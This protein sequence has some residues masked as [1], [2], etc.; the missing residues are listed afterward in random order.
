M[1]KPTR[2][3]LTARAKDVDL[4]ILDV[5][6]VLTDGGLYYGPE[7]EAL[8]RFNVRDGHG[9][10]LARATGLRAAILTGRRS[11]IV[12][13]R[14][15]ELGISPISQGN[16]DKVAGLARLLEEAKVPASRAGYVGDDLN[17]LGPMLQVR[18]RACPADACAEVRANS[19]YVAEACGG[20]GAVREI[21]E[22]L[23]KAQGRWDDALAAMGGGSPF[24]RIAGP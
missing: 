20:H 2:R 4:L 9:L 14:G 23:L 21:L 5:D 11:R 17:D 6:G 13:A 1:K 24:G 3:E 10:V 22:L 19:H 7:G 18:F 15:A 16:K 12:E 8:K